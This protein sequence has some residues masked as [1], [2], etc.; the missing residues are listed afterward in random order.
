MG[1]A[2]HPIRGS[3]LHQTVTFHPL[4]RLWRKAGRELHLHLHHLL[5]GTG[6]WVLLGPEGSISDAFRVQAKLLWDK[7]P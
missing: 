3:E 2:R 5:V 7:Q 6:G 1:T 4:L